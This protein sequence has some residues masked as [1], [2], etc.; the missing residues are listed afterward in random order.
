M[1]GAV[2]VGLLELDVRGNG[3]GGNIV[4]VGGGVGVRENFAAKGD[5]LGLYL[6]PGGRKIGP[7]GGRFFAWH[8]LGDGEEGSREKGERGRVGVTAAGEIGVTS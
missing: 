6:S 4:A 2:V 8:E 7:T 5:E 1:A 3:S